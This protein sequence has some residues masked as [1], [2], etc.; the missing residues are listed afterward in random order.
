MLRLITGILLIFTLL[1][2]CEPAPDTSKGA[3]L[4]KIYGTYLYESDLA[5][6]VPTGT[7]TNDSM[8]LVKNF[9]DKWLE[10]RMLIRQAER[11]LTPGQTD[12]SKKM[13]DYR[14]SLIIYTYETELIS[15]KLDTIVDESEIERYYNENKTNFELKYNIVKVVYV[16]LP[17]DSK[18]VNQFRKLL[19]NRTVLNIDSLN[20]LAQRHAIAYY[21]DEENWIKFDDLLLQIPLVA[22][23][24][25][26]FLN[27][28]RFVEFVDEPFVYLVLFRDFMMRESISPLEFEH[29][30][31]MNIILNKRKQDLIKQMHADVYEQAL[32]NKDFELY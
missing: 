25:E 32:R 20:T 11:N 2:S 22:Y 27:N 5:G 29:D 28:N 24:Q 26:V 1:V 8:M 31:I 7:S 12:F 30:H 9:I 21:L 6:V 14:N 16:I 18:A 17:T 3:V 4:A 15:Q 19:K 23:N 13:E 10:K